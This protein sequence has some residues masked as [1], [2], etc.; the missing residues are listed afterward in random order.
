VA[1][2]G[3]IVALVD[4]R[5]ALAGALATAFA[6]EYRKDGK[7]SVTIAEYLNAEEFGRKRVQLAGQ[8]F[9]AILVAGSVDDAEQVRSDLDTAKRTVPLLLGGADGITTTWADKPGIEVYSASA[10]ATE[11]LSEKGSAFARRYQE[12]VGERVDLSAALSADATHFLYDALK[13]A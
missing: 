13:Q 9:D 7:R 3:P 5:N 2:G 12:K 1:K 8:T 11:G 6:R 10:F 4:G